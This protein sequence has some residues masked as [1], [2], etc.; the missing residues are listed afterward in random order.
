MGGRL[1]L[2][3]DVERQGFRFTGNGT[4][5]PLLIGGLPGV[6]TML[7]RNLASLIFASWN[8]LC[9]WLK[10]VDGLRHAA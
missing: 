2:V 7:S 3:A 5:V 6:A 10:A 9:G 4:L 1:E 8:Q